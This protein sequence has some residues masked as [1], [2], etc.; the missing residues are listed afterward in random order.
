MDPVRIEMN[1]GLLLLVLSDLDTAARLY[2]KL[3][4]RCVYEPYEH[5][6]DYYRVQPPAT[7][8]PFGPI[9]GQKWFDQISS[10]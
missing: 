3:F 1:A 10:L 9:E 6:D 8:P 5:S 7:L 4:E 2:D